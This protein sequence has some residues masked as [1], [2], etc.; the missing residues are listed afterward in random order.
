MSF[1]ADG[2]ETRLR[3]WFE[4][5]NI[6]REDRPANYIKKY[7]SVDFK[8]KDGRFELTYVPKNDYVQFEAAYEDGGSEFCYPETYDSLY[9][10]TLGLGNSVRKNL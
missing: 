1:S 2:I 5:D 9:D 7:D 4:F 10:S 6:Q 8:H 3:K